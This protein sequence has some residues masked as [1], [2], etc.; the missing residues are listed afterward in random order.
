MMT[1]IRRMCVNLGLHSCDA[2]YVRCLRA[3]M[4]AIACLTA[5][6]ADSPR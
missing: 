2:D 4:I 3:A 1:D 5:L 6:A